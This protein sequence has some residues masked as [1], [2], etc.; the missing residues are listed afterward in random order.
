M[1]N[2]FNS[3]ND[4]DTRV[5]TPDA[6]CITSE[7]VFVSTIEIPEGIR[8]IAKS[9]IKHGLQEI[10]G[11]TFSPIEFI[12]DLTGIEDS[13]I[14]I[15]EPTIDHIIPNNSTTIDTEELSTNI[16][17]N[18]EQYWDETSTGDQITTELSTE[19]DFASTSDEILL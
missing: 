3:N 13:D 12:N 17:S 8:K 4:I 16:H 6:L 18:P 19:Q 9:S 10:S 7:G 11:E 1:M 15:V 5:S 14:P 2:D